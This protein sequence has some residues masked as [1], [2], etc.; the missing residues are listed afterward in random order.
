M[1][2]L[3]LLPLAAACVPNSTTQAALQSALQ[4]GGAG[5]VLSLCPGQVYDLTSSLNYTAPRQEISTAGYPVD[6]TRAVLRVVGGMCAV[7]GN[8]GG[9]DGIALRHVQVDGGREGNVGR[10]GEGNI[11]VGGS[12]SGQVV[13]WVRTFNPRGWTCLHV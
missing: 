7:R 5:F 13:E 2:K 10:G 11:E 12:N 9:L 1:L 6:G 3:A 8:A 4:S